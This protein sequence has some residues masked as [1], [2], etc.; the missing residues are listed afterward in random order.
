MGEEK[1]KPNAN[2][3]FLPKPSLGKKL[4]SYAGFCYDNS[5]IAIPQKTFSALIKG[6]WVIFL[7]N[8]PNRPQEDSLSMIGDVSARFPR[9]FLPDSGFAGD[10]VVK[11]WPV[12]EL[13]P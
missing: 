8:S 6:C 3:H 1:A 5:S 13:L 11:L 9:S 10:A 12:H 2:L 4:V 7:K